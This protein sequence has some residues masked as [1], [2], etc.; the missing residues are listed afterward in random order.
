MQRISRSIAAMLLA[1][2]VLGVAPLLPNSGLPAL[3]P[4]TASGAYAKDTLYKRLGGYDGIAAVTDD[5][6]G[7]LLNDRM[8]DRF[9][10]GISNDSKGRLRQN[11][12]DFICK[13]AEGPCY[14][15]GRD[16][17]MAH[18]GIGISKAEWDKATGYFVEAMQSLNVPEQEQKDLTALILPLEKD[19]VEKP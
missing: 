15:M 14:Y 7:R 9:F 4:L 8:F 11:I 16:M 6:V 18:A 13:A 19:I 3:V 1:A 5:F 12:V 2:P 17:K 10:A